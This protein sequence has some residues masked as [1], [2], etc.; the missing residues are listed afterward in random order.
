MKV[1]EERMCCAVDNSSCENLYAT[2][3]PGSKAFVVAKRNA[4]AVSDCENAKANTLAVVD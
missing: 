3:R 2:G 4:L 1:K